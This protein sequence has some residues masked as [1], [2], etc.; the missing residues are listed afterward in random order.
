MQD[1]L[2]SVTYEEPW[3]PTGHLSVT[4]PGILNILLSF[5][6]Q[7]SLRRTIIKGVSV[8]IFPSLDFKDISAKMNIVAL[9]TFSYASQIGLYNIFVLLFGFSKDAQ[10]KLFQHFS[11]TRISVMYQERCPKNLHNARFYF[12]VKQQSILYLCASTSGSQGL[13]HI[14]KLN[15]HL[16]N[17]DSNQIPYFQP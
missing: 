16:L 14:H 13:L 7:I 4:V 2:I 15:S 3:H 10:S 9:H 1:L 6:L 8:G 12:S 11:E 5:Q 17:I